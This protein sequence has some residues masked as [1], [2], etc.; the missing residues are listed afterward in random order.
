M[1]NIGR[2]AGAVFSLTAIAAALV[3]IVLTAQ[4]LDHRPRTDD[5][6]IDADVV[7]MAPDVS[8]RVVALNVRDNQPVRA[9]D[10]L[11]TIDPEPFRLQLAQARAQLAGLIAQLDVT[12]DQVASQNSK[13][14]AAN[15]QIGSAQAQLSLATSTLARLTPLLPRGFV[16]PQ[17]VDQAR[18]S[19]RTAQ[20]ALQQARQQAQEA[21]QGVTSVKPVEQQIAAARAAL[22]LAE[23]NLRLTDVR[24][25]CAGVITGLDIAAGEYAAAGHPLFTI[26]DTEQWYAVGNFRE[27]ALD[28]V[29]PGQR[30]A[31]YVLSAP[32]HPV[33]GVVDS[34]GAGVSP[35]EG[36]SIGGLPHVPRSL[37]WVRIAQRFP[38]RIRLLSPPPAIMRLGASSVIVID[39]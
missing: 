25:P 3:A 39:R 17:Q 27:T 33:E 12:T 34:L 32:S 11:F 30:A 8:G 1:Q 36:I 2:V 6:F 14:D 10:V 20:I 38:V 18:T 4:R 24:S 35:D 9:G 19:Q 26:I 16:T 29:R 5:A 37:S 31:I 22:A 23:R 21:K 13:A 28:G 15:T 7:H